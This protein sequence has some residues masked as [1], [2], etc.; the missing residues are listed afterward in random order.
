VTPFKPKHEEESMGKASKQG[1]ANLERRRV[2]QAAAIGAAGAFGI[3]GRAFAQ[4]GSGLGLPASLIE[5]AKKEGT[6]VPYESFPT[7]Q[8]K[9]MADAFTAEFGI[10]NKFFRAGQE[11][12]QTRLEAEIRG[13]R[14]LADTIAQADLD[15]VEHMV[16]RG[17]ID[18]ESR[19]SLWDQY[20]AE[21][22]YPEFNNIAFA[23]LSCNMIYNN[24]L[25]AAGDAPRT[26]E[27]LISPKWK[28]K[29]VIPSP[30]YAGTGFALLAEWVKRY[31]WDFVK[32]LKANQAFIAQAVSDSDSRVISGQKL[33]GI[34]NSHRGSTLIGQG[35]P[36]TFVWSQETPPVALSYV[37]AVLKKAPNPNAARLYRDFCLTPKIQSQQAKFGLWSAHP[38]ATQPAHL[39]HLSEVK[40]AR[41][42]W[43]EIKKTRQKLLDGWRTIIRG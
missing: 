11:A 43:D 24:K 28:G 17:L 38:K 27:D 15:V 18:T 42:D 1:T 14:V 2:L 13:G 21:W 29:V 3:T 26:W 36:I 25:V 23:T 41:L 20:P 12:L 30:E 31:G 9:P 39:P 16:E 7:A 22:R 8:S 4:A 6:L 10:E 19:P 35:A 40:L 5:G 33:V 34:A 37:H 32:A